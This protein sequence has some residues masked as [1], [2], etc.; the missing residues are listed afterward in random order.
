M[1]AHSAARLEPVDFDP[2]ESAECVRILAQDPSVSATQRQDPTNLCTFQQWLTDRFPKV[3]QTLQSLK[4][5]HARPHRRAKQSEHSHM[6]AGTGISTDAATTRH[7]DHQQQQYANGC[8]DKHDDDESESDDNDDDDDDTPQQQQQQC[9]QYHDRAARS[10]KGQNSA[11]RAADRARM[12]AANVEAWQ[13]LFGHATLHVYAPSDA[14]VVQDATRTGYVYVVLNGSC[15]LTFQPTFLELLLLAKRS[16]SPPK[17]TIELSSTHAGEPLP[18]SRSPRAAAVQRDAPDNKRRQH[19]SANARDKHTPELATSPPLASAAASTHTTDAAPP[20]TRSRKRTLGSRKFSLSHLTDQ[21][22]QRAFETGVYLQ[23]LRTGDFFGLDA[24]MFQFATHM[25]SATSNGALQRSDIGLT[26]KT[27]MHVLCIPFV[28]FERMRDAIASSVPTTSRCSSRHSASSNSNG[29][30]TAR[31]NASASPLSPP[32]S[33]RALLQAARPLE[34]YF[35]Y[36]FSHESVEFLR[37]TFF[38]QSI[39]ESSL[40]FLA[41][42]MRTQRVA[43][44]EYLF[45]PGQHVAGL[46]LVKTG[47]LKVSSLEQ[48]RVSISDSE[49]EELL[50]LFESGKGSSNNSTS[51]YDRSNGGTSDRSRGGGSSTT[52]PGA[53]GTEP[54]PTFET[55]NVELEILQAHDTIGLLEVCLLHSQFATHCIAISDDVEVAVLSTVALFAVL[56]REQTASKQVVES[57]T[58]HHAWYKARQLAALNHHST[59]RE[60][61]LSIAVQQRGPIQCSRCGWTGHVSTSSICVRAESPKT[62]L[63]RHASTASSSN[64]SAA[65]KLTSGRDRRISPAVTLPLPSRRSRTQQRLSSLATI[66]AVSEAEEAATACSSN[67]LD[68]QASVSFAGSGAT[69]AAVQASADAQSAAHIRSAPIVHADSKLKAS[70]LRGLLP[71][72]CMKSTRSELVAEQVGSSATDLERALKR[73]DIALVEGSSGEERDASAHT[74]SS[75]PPLLQQSHH[76]LVDRRPDTS[77]SDRR[78]DSSSSTAKVAATAREAPAATSTVVARTRPHT[79]QG[80]RRVFNLNAATEQ[81]VSRI[82]AAITSASDG[83]SAKSMRVSSHSPLMPFA[84]VLTS[85]SADESGNPRRRHVHRRNAANL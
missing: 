41:S 76:P 7:M 45:T 60:C 79:E 77:C 29:C 70:L 3:V 5:I 49:R 81:A 27:C 13:T 19:R 12:R 64:S 74:P 46:Y 80:A 84:A 28:A 2:F 22:A 14:V 15:D 10:G 20:T 72:L 62:M 33:R 83:D 35:P 54:K 4:L 61:K 39:A 71:F 52:T 82:S 21:D 37:Q 53:T 63:S 59:Q 56:A 36:T 75:R 55:R 40:Q 26:T 8:E 57:L 73:L 9:Q 58:R 38:F 51:S 24:A 69:V 1:S 48:V 44:H 32:R 50:G 42:Q 78:T 30:A 18:L 23:T 68:I 16:K 66:A 65:S 67:Q 85:K 25:A 31:P 11:S 6:N 34:S 43:R 17:K 47:Q